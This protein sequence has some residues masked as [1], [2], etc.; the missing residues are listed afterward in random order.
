M[1]RHLPRSAVVLCWRDFGSDVNVL[2][3]RATVIDEDDVG[4]EDR[5][6]E[7]VQHTYLAEDPAKAAQF[8]SRNRITHWMITEADLYRLPLME[9]LAGRT[10]A[11][12]ELRVV[13]LPLSGRTA[14]AHPDDDIA[15]PKRPL[16][17]RIS[18]PL[19]LNGLANARAPVY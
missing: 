19:T 12:S 4:K 14:D 7:V 15:S 2:A 16:P 13:D 17:A 6:A 3:H 9:S 11:S 5:I 10:A 8:L 18:D 1:D